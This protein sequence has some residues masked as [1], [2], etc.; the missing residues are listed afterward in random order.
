MLQRGL[1]VQFLL[2][3]HDY[4]QYSESLSVCEIKDTIFMDEFVSIKEIQM[5]PK[6]F[7]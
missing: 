2:K 5:Q 7:L 4:F 1:K 3:L 6:L